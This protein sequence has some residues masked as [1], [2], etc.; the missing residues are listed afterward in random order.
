MRKKLKVFGI[1]VAVAIIGLGF[2]NTIGAEEGN[3]VDVVYSIVGDARGSF[4]RILELPAKDFEPVGLVFTESAARPADG[5]GEIFTFHQLLREANALGAHGIINVNIDSV[6]V[7]RRVSGTEE[8]VSRTYFG[9]ALAIRYTTTLPPGITHITDSSGNI[10]VSQNF[11]FMGTEGLIVQHGITVGVEQPLLI[12]RAPLQPL[13]RRR[14]PD[15]LIGTI[16]GVALIGGLAA[17]AA[18]F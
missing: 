9:S 11:N 2:T 14:V 12:E 6:E 5:G 18:A 1:I 16:I 3:N 17:A 7:S 10:L 13:Q 8:L 4:V 15:W